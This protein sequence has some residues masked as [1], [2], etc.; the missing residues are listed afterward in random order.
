MKGYKELREKQQK[1]TSDFLSQHGFFAFD[2]RQYAAGVEK[3]HTDDVVS[4]GGGGFIRADQAD[5]LS[6]LL[7]SQRRE[8]RD[9]LQDPDFAREAFQTELINTE[10]SYTGDVSDALAGLGLTVEDV[11]ADPVLADALDF[12]CSQ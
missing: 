3:L 12:V 7:R 10:Y 11:N 1:A 2:D 6:D 8:L 4:I 5:A 9:A